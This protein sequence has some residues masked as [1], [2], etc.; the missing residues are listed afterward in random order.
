MKEWIDMGIRI[1]PMEIDVPKDDPFKSDLL[2]RKSSVEILTH[3]LGAIEG[4]CVLA[5]DGG[6][7]ARKTTFLRIWSQHLRNE[8]FP[9]RIHAWETDFAGDPFVALS[10]EVTEGL[11]D[12]DK[13][14]GGALRERSLA[15]GGLRKRSLVEAFQA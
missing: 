13:R 5:V 12:C 4:P 3:L 10:T 14:A 6:W 8:A 9:C 2:D 7:G 15:R 11:K 1:Q